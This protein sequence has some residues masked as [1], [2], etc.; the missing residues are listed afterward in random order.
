M[1]LVDEVVSHA[2]A[3]VLCRTTIREDMP[4]VHSGEVP[5]LIALELFA[6]SACTLFALAASDGGGGVD[7]FGGCEKL[8]AACGTY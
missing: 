1:L 8:F 6:Q 7:C 2:G 5:L 4:F 3:T